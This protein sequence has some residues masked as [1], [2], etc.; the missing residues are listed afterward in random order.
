MLGYSKSEFMK[1]NLKLCD[2]ID[3]FINPELKVIFGIKSHLNN[4]NT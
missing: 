1:H 3:N 2:E 4:A